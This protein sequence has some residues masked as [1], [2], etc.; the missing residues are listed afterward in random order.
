M[1]D[2]I[3]PSLSRIHRERERER[4]KQKGSDGRGE[5]VYVGGAIGGRPSALAYKPQSKELFHTLPN[6]CC[7]WQ[8]YKCVNTVEAYSGTQTGQGIVMCKLHNHCRRMK[9]AF[10]SMHIPPECV[11]HA[12]GYT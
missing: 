3:R 11:K 7:H 8:M 5:G 12:C 10:I 9:T 6:T 2:P 1:G 4:K